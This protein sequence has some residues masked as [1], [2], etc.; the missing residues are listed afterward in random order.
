AFHVPVNDEFPAPRA[1]FG[2]HLDVS[3]TLEMS[4]RCNKYFAAMIDCSDSG[5]SPQI[6]NYKCV[7]PEYQL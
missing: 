2:K 6:Q 3:P 7:H 1:E 4:A 5:C